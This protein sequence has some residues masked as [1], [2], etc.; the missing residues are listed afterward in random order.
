MR[1]AEQVGSRTDYPIRDAEARLIARHVRVDNPDGTKRSM[2]WE[3]PDGSK[4]LNE[5]P[6]ED[7][8]LYGAE[9]VGDWDEDDLIVVVEGEKARDS[10]IRAG[11]PALGTVTGAAGVPGQEALEVL[12]NRRVCLWP[13]ED[14]AGRK[15]ME[16]VAE[17][18]HDIA[19]EVLVYTWREAPED[20]K[21]PE[22]L[23]TRRCSERIQ[24]PWTGCLPTWR[25][26]PVGSRHPWASSLN[27]TDI[28]QVSQCHCH[29][30][31]V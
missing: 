20:V 1:A 4:G 18:L 17:R 5:T 10:L 19:A 24:G 14:D 22:P 25:M 9:Q 16:R 8:P 21:G 12:R 6:L 13:D 3:L 2:W 26:P 27:S 29:L 28:N 30:I 31:R 23:T 7:L 15:H 11:L